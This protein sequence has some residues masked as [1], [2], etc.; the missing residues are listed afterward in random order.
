MD[1]SVLLVARK[2][3]SSLSKSRKDDS[4]DLKVLLFELRGKFDKVFYLSA[5]FDHILYR[6]LDFGHL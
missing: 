3:E 5:T 6:S 1:F 2:R 4:S